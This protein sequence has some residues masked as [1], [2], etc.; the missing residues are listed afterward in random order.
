MQLPTILLLVLVSAAVV[1]VVFLVRLLIQLRATAG[2]AQKTLAEVR[3]LAQNLNELDLEIKTRVEEMGDAVGVFRKAA[4]D[5]S[6]AALLAAWRFLPAPA[7]YLSLILPAARY[8]A[9]QIKKGKEDQNV[10]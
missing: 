1:A 6:K 2:E 5:V 4:G 9:R 10:E 3:V 8:I 7:K